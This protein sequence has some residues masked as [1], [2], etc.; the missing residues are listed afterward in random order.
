MI[1]ERKASSMVTEIK[2]SL[3]E[4]INIL[5]TT[6]LPQV[7]GELLIKDTDTDETVGACALGQI[8]YFL[9][10]NAPNVVI[11]GC[12]PK[13][14]ISDLITFNDTYKFSLEKIASRLEFMYSTVSEDT[15]VSF[16]IVKD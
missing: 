7:F 1:T 14:L 16:Y 12:F 9:N 5:R 8:Q 3:P 6:E 15:F 2:I 11:G 4:I 13:T 10:K